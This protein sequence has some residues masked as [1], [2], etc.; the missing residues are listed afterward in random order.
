M[1]E[2]LAPSGR[3]RGRTKRK[4][5]RSLLLSEG[6]EPPAFSRH[7][8]GRKQEVREREEPHEDLDEEAERREPR[9]RCFFTDNAYDPKEPLIIFLK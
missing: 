9:F 4:R 8:V 7:E 5:A 6:E 2:E 3:E 1:N